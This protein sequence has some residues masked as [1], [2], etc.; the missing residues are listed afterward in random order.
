M[1]DL[2]TVSDIANRWKCCERTVQKV[3]KSGNLEIIEI[4]EKIIRVDFSSLL[5]YENQRKIK[6]C[7]SINVVKF[8]GSSSKLAVKELDSLLGRPQSAKRSSSREN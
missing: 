5:D 6:R 8:T 7:Q 4:S 3:I 1:T 2:L